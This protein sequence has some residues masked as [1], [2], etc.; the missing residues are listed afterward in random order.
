M[1]TIFTGV[2]LFAIIAIYSTPDFAKLAGAWIHSHGQA[3]EEM[4]ARRK[5]LYEEKTR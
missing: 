2:V 3:L 1:T 4:R 5:A